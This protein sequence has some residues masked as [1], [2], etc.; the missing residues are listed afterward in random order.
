MI[1]DGRLIA[2]QIQDRIAK[3]IYHGSARPPGLAF[4]LVGDNPG[5]RTY[6][7][8]KKKK[9]KEVGILSFDREFPE[10]IRESELLQEIHDLNNDPAIDGILVQLPLPKHISTIKVTE[11]ISPDK[12]VDGFHPMNVGKMLLGEQDGFLPCTPHGIVVMLAESTI[13]VE[14][15]HVV[16]LGRSNIV[17]KPLGAILM[18]KAPH[19]NATVTI[20]HSY[21][22]NLPDIC[23]SADILI[24]A[25]GQPHFV[26]KE[27]VRNGAVVI[28]VG[29]NKVLDGS[30]QKYQIIG[31]VD[32]EEVAPLCS[33]ISPVPGG[34]G[35]MTI[36]MLLSNT[37]LSFERR[38]ML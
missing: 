32:F 3:T 1:I 22:E 36:A 16:I 35:P 23:K 8:M 11:A 10:T 33:H 13:P 21:T 12:D 7:Q 29:I 9:C 17:G 18:Q 14:G 5:S 19:C 28:D 20:A 4:L 31:D 30:S 24:A 25:L 26:K 37:L 38:S 34:V 2:K 27:M 15:K 6:I